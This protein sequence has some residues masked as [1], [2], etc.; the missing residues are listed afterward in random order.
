MQACKAPQS[1]ISGV[2]QARASKYICSHTARERVR[3]REVAHRAATG[4]RAGQARAPEIV[5][6]LLRR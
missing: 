2:A 1:P 6:V 5:R 4:A 3:D